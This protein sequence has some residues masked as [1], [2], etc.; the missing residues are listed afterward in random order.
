MTTIALIGGDGAGKTTVA[1]ALIRS[2]SAPVKYLYMGLSTRSSDHALPTSRFVYW[3]KRQRHKKQKAQSGVKDPKSMPANELEYSR[4]SHGWIWNT[5][6][7]L[8]RMAEAGYRQI[9]AVLYQLEGKIVLYDRHFFF[10]ATPEELNLQSR[11]TLFYDRLFFWLMNHLYPRPA[12]AIFLDAP[13][14]V[15]FSRKGE[16]SPDY[17]AW[18]REQYMKQGAKLAHFIRVDATQ[19]LEDVIHEVEQ[20]IQ[21]IHTGRAMKSSPCSLDVRE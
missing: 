15:L 11:S 13:P 10:D 17:L 5:A 3:L 18:Q 7:F 6:R 21:V 4:E 20:I 19:P 2:T 12:V 14:D 9:L 16:A 1:H 8:N